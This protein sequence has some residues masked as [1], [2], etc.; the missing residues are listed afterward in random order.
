VGGCVPWNRS[1]DG[2]EVDPRKDYSSGRHREAGTGRPEHVT[3]VL[4]GLKEMISRLDGE[5]DP[6]FADRGVQVVQA[7]RTSQADFFFRRFLADD[8]L[9]V[10]Q[11]GGDL[12]VLAGSSF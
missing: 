7:G 10:P 6:D 12:A 2:A 3:Q 11:K 5:G 4:E 9:C 1:F 8:E